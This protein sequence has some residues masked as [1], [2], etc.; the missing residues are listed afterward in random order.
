[1]ESSFPFGSV[2]LTLMEP[3]TKF[4]VLDM[5]LTLA[6]IIVNSRKYILFRRIVCVVAQS[7]RHT[8]SLFMLRPN[9][10]WI[11]DITNIKKI[12]SIM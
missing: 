10:T 4:V 12:K 1:M 2:M 5:V 9:N 11:L 8:S 7:A 6:F 3:S